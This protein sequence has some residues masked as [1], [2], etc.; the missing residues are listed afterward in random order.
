MLTHV[1]ARTFRRLAIGFLGV[2]VLAWVSIDFLPG[3]MTSISLTAMAS[4]A[5]AALGLLALGLS[6]VKRGARE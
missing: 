2:A 6:F 5:L 1:P 4:V 3:T